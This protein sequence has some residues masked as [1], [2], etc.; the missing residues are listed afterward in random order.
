VFKLLTKLPKNLSVACSGGVDSMALLDFLRLRHNVTACFFHHNTETSSKAFNF[1]SS[2]CLENSIPLQVDFLVDECPKGLSMEEHWRNARYQF[3]HSIEGVVVTAHHLDDC[4][5]TY[6][7]NCLH[8]K[9]H[10]IPLWRN[11]VVRPFLTTPKS[12]FVSWC[13]RHVVPWVE[14]SSNFDFKYMRNHIRH[15]IVPEAL[16]VNPGLRK[17]VKKIVLQSL[18]TEKS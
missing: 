2:Y 3:L 8:G 1:L 18:K 5:E 6:L 12:V 9:S 16:K 4:V 10:T 7:F 11:N 15:R 17:V 13:E 14:D